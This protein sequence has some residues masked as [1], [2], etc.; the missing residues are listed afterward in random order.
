MRWR[1]LIKLACLQRLN[2]SIWRKKNW[3]ESCKELPVIIWKQ[4]RPSVPIITTTRNK[5]EA[6]RL[7]CMK[8]DS[9][10]QPPQSLSNT[11]WASKRIVKLWWQTLTA[12]RNPYHAKQ[13]IITTISNN[14]PKRCL[15]SSRHH[16]VREAWNKI[17]KAL[18]P[19]AKPLKK[20]TFHSLKCVNQLDFMALRRV[21]DRHHRQSNTLKLEFHTRVIMS[22]S[23]ASVTKPIQC[24][25][26][27]LRK[28]SSHP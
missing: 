3:L 15:R 20:T 11:F 7:N 22:A 4:L 23:P 25:T 1:K 28:S 24:R 6:R 26:R 19:R 16:K 5:R 13:L 10:H 9:F 21:K 17:S 12:T 18:W 27:A 14:S 8:A 2:N